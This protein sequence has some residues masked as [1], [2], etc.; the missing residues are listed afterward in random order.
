METTSLGERVVEILLKREALKESVLE[1]ARA[2]AAAAGTRL[3]KFLVEKNLVSGAEM[4]LALAEYLKMPPL[5]LA[6]FTPSS[7]LLDLIPRENL[8]K[9]LMVPVTRSGRMLT[10]A[11]GAKLFNLY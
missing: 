8:Q 6:H 11:L 4:T 7:D 10:V 9:H 1:G 2:D 3:E 5:T